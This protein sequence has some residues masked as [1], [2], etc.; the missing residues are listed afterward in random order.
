M[1]QLEIVPVGI[2]TSNI[3]INNRNKPFC[4]M[5]FSTRTILLLLAFC[6]II[7]LCSSAQVVKQRLL[8]LSDIE[9]DPDDAQSLVRLLLYSNELD[10]EGL[11]A[12]TSTHQRLRVAPETM[13][14]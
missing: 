14:K 11:V 4:K 12:T 6:L 3:Q 1:G 13:H 5:K 2:C 10:I 8:V 9:A 7:P